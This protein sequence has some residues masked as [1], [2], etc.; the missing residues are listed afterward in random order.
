MR[1]AAIRHP[2]QI[3]LRIVRPNTRQSSSAQTS[4][5]PHNEKTEPGRPILLPGIQPSFLGG[6]QLSDHY[7]LITR[8]EKN[9]TYDR[10]LDAL[11]GS[12]AHPCDQC[13]V[14]RD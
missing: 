14:I 11:T 7:E 6:E 10:D 2:C 4:I 3:A 8:P 1:S 12:N 5:G 9:V 13:C